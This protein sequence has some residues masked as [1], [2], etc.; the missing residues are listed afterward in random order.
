[1][2]AFFDLIVIDEFYWS[3]SADD[4]AQREIPEYF[5]PAIRIDLTAKPKEIKYGSNIACFGEPAYSRSLKQCIRD[6]FFASELET[7]RT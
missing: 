6:G 1:M 4:S 5:S 3:S 2:S 7:P